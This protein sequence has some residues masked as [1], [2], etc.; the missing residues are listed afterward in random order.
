MTEPCGALP[1]KCLFIDLFVEF[2]QDHRIHIFITEGGVST[3]EEDGPPCILLYAPKATF[4][5]RCESIPVALRAITMCYGQ[6]PDMPDP[7]RTKE[8]ALVAAINGGTVDN[9]HLVQLEQRHDLEEVAAWNKETFIAG[10]ATQPYGSGLGKF[11]A[12]FHPDE[13]YSATIAIE[14]GAHGEHGTA[15]LFEQGTRRCL[16][17]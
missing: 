4:K 16:L 11:T 17:T 6:E 15:I 13:P 14:K 10:L 8:W 3:P 7:H 5:L 1:R 12:R 9:K 2:P